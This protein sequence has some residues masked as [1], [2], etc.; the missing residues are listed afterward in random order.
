MVRLYFQQERKYFPDQLKKRYSQISY[1][2]KELKDFSKKNYF[3]ENNISR[4]L[5]KLWAFFVA[6]IVTISVIAL[7]LLFIPIEVL[8]S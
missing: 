6:H 3:K 4:F 7:L 5:Q 1:G 8:I 2:F